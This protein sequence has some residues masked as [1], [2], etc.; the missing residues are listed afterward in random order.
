MQ[1]NNFVSF[2]DLPKRPKSLFSHLEQQGSLAL[3]ETHSAGTE[4]EWRCRQALWFKLQTELYRR[5]FGAIRAKRI[6]RS[7]EVST[8]KSDFEGIFYR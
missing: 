4:N 8:Q 6:R 7:A 2:L 1:S 5:D 3:L